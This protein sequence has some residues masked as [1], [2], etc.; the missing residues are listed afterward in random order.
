[1]D[2]TKKEKKPAAMVIQLPDGSERTISFDELTLS[3]NLAIEAIVRILSKK[4]ILTPEDFVNELEDI[5]K[6]RN[7]K[8]KIETVN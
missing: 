8:P 4:G 2:D 5:E 7:P 3:N 6:E 1:M